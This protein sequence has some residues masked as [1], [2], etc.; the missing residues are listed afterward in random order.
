MQ[1]RILMYSDAARNK[2]M[3]GVNALTKMV[4]VTLGPKG[5]NVVIDK[6]F[7]GPLIS[8]DGITVAAEIFLKDPIENMGA[9]LIR[10]VAAKTAEVAGDGTTTAT[11]LAQA[12]ISEGLRS[13][14]AGANPMDIKR[15]IDLATKAVV[16]ELKKISKPVDSKE[17]I[18]NIGSISSNN[19]RL[20]GALI[21]DAMEKVGKEGV[22]T[23]EDAKG[24]ETDIEI[25]EGMQ[26]DRGYLSPYFITKIETME[27]ILDNVHI[28][29]YDGKI[30][31]V[32][33][34]LE[35]LN[36]IAERGDSLLV[37]AE[38]VVGDA[39]KT[40]VINKM[41]SKIKVCAVKAPG[42]GD[43]RK[44]I[45]EDIAV[46]TGGTVI[47]EETGKMLKTVTFKDFGHAEKV[48]ISRDTTVIV[49]GDGNE[50]NIQ[51]R[52]EQLKKQIDSSTSDFD[53]EKFQER[54]AKMA[55]GVAVLRVGAATDTE[56]KEK[57][58]RIEDALHATRAAV[59]EGIVP[60]GGVAYVRSIPPR[61]FDIGNEDQN[62][63][64][65][66]VM[67]AITAPLKCIADNSGTNGEVVLNEVR[68]SDVVDYGYD[69]QNG[70]YCS[71]FEAGIID[72]TKVVRT[73]LENASSIAG[74]FLTTEG[75]I[76]ESLEEKEEQE[77]LM[78]QQPAY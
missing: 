36:G 15:G 73:A 59:D 60:G 4:A 8:K 70:K 14:A 45:L 33:D 71:L 25:V 53:K 38:D 29:I 76:A 69:A 78:N 35:I 17:D 55:G 1:E 24:L 19:D 32:N 6:K 26:F 28:L 16:E 68:K 63:G 46:L 11:V 50:V 10:S 62:I 49:N 22:I 41:Q 51:A 44:D 7:G 64:V 67:K 21:A 3:I 34:I 39:I 57:K 48:V 77:K 23:V 13:V 56:L 18:I 61:I 75:V 12:I 9:Q 27:A 37:I 43:R 20:I 74:L 30:S 31:L 72:P 47:S 66:I 52:V 2:L 42:F 54:L 65:N 5:R 40:L 58:M